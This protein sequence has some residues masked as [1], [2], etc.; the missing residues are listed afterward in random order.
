MRKVVCTAEY[1][2]YQRRSKGACRIESNI[3]NRAECKNLTCDHQA[4]DQARPASRRTAINSCSHDDQ[5]QEEG[6]N[7]LHD[8]GNHPATT[9]TVEADRTTKVRGA[10]TRALRCSRP[11]KGKSYDQR[12]QDSPNELRNPVNYCLTPG[13]AP[14]N[15]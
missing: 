8:D 13:D 4:D 3:G 12:T 5:Q 9:R 6:A 11:A 14:G 2:S 15:S 10:K 1:D 7:C